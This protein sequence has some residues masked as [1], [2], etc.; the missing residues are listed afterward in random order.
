MEFPNTKHLI[1]SYRLT[2]IC[3]NDDPYTWHKL[4]YGL[5]ACYG[6]SHAFLV[7]Y[8]DSIERLAKTL[9]VNKSFLHI[10]EINDTDYRAEHLRRNANGAAL[11]N[12]DFAKNAC[13]INS[14]IKYAE[15]NNEHMIATIWVEKYSDWRHIHFKIAEDL[16][17]EVCFARI[18]KN[19][20]NSNIRL[21]IESGENAWQ[22][23]QY[24]LDKKGENFS[25]V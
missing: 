20:D 5:N 23:I 22:Y 4:V 11:K 16:K 7:P 17:D 8:E 24:R 10:I 25:E 3:I 1:D 21:Q 2:V 18:I 19:E 6:F 9:S 14:L 15:Q 12:N 13:K